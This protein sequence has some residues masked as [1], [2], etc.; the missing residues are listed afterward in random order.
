MTALKPCPWCGSK[1]KRIQFGRWY[2]V[3]CEFE[4][5][6]VKPVTNWY[7]TQSRATGVWNRRK[8]QP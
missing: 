1:P 6:F 5:C 8:D 2:S 7:S 3:R 4:G